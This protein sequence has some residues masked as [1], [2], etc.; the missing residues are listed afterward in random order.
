MHFPE[1]DHFFDLNAISAYGKNGASEWVGALSTYFRSTP[2][3]KYYGTKDSS[4][5][6]I[7][8][9]NDQKTSLSIKNHSTFERT[10][11]R[12]AVEPI[13]FINTQRVTKSPEACQFGLPLESFSSQN[14][15]NLID[16]SHDLSMDPDNFAPRD[17]TKAYTKSYKDNMEYKRTCQLVST[18]VSADNLEDS[19]ERNHLLLDHSVVDLINRRRRLAELIYDK[20]GAHALELLSQRISSELRRSARSPALRLLEEC[21]RVEFTV[22][23]TSPV[24]DKKENSSQI[25]TRRYFTM[26]QSHILSAGF[27][28][29]NLPIQISNLCSAVNHANPVI[30]RYLSKEI[31]EKE[32]T[33]LYISAMTD[34]RSKISQHRLVEVLAEIETPKLEYPQQR[35][36]I[37]TNLVN[38]GLKLNRQISYLYNI[39]RI[40]EIA[41]NI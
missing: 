19:I 17:R 4:T 28:N 2:P 18:L 26:R 27:L 32:I 14:I 35:V 40:L 31:F 22:K 33:Q 21:L 34:F 16:P 11:E 36:I 20:P 15:A 25:D 30:G 41:K 10:G 23:N 24:L 37:A 38:K 7:S 13:H 29:R 9:I 8:Y 39:A 5:L 6:P 12:N 3:D 1:R